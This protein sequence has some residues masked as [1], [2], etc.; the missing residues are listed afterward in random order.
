MFIFVGT[1]FNCQPLEK[2]NNSDEKRK[3]HTGLD[4]LFDEELGLIKNKRIALVTNQSGIDRN[5]TSNVSLFLEHKDLNLIKIFSPEHGFSGQFANGEIVKGEE[6]DNVPPINSL[7]GKTKKPT[8]DMLRDV[9]VIV[10]DIQDV[11]A[12]FYTYISTLGLVME[13]AAEVG[14]PVIV[15]DRPNP[16]GITVEGPILE[17]DYSSFIGKYPIPIR[18]GMTVGELAKMIV[19]ENMIKLAP[20]LKVVKMEHYHYQY[21]DETYLPWSK[22][23]PNIPD[24]E[25]AVIYPGICTLEATNIGEGRGTLLPFKQIGA[26]WIVADDLVE[27]LNTLDLRG[28]EFSTVTFTPKSIPSMS[29][30]PKYENELCNGIHIKVTNRDQYNS[31]KAGIGVLWAVYKLYPNNIHIN[32]SS[33]ARLW[34]SDKLFKMIKDGYSI[35]EILESYQVDLQE[36]AD[37]RKKYLLYD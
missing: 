1:L 8:Y 27:L 19:D 33:L 31:V 17:Q 16:I 4:V 3:V 23:S 32:E 36:F 35:N 28:V 25:T 7:Y 15:L 2:L 29:K 22:P 9:D 11:G 30:Y 5:G 18:Y 20:E 12:R 37:L 24:L 13:A 34:G 14:I 26:P 21:F 10:Y 6:L